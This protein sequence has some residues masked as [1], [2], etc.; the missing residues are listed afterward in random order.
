MRPEK[1][2]EKVRIRMLPKELSETKEEV[3]K[4]HAQNKGA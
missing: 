2:E 4:V 1:D 3:S